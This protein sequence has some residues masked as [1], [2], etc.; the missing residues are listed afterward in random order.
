MTHEQRVRLADSSF[1]DWSG[2]AQ[3]MISRLGQLVTRATI[4]HIGSTSVPGLPAKPVVDVIVGVAAEAVDDT[5]QLLVQEG[6]DL[7]GKKPL[8]SWLSFPD[9]TARQY[10]IHVV[11]DQGRQFQRR[12]LFRDTL[13]RMLARDT[14]KL[15]RELPNHRGTGTNT[16]TRRLKWFTRYSMPRSPG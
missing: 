1:E 4:E 5:T 7:E 8:H 10:V 14:S 9:R 13:T 11:E 6:F 15:R 12:I 3:L 16:P 2:M